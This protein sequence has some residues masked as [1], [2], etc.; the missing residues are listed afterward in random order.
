MASVI[1]TFSY[2]MPL[3]KQSTGPQISTNNCGVHALTCHHRK[4]ETCVTME[5]FLILCTFIPVNALC[6]QNNQSELENREFLM[7]T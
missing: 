4:Q 1:L 2:F 5:T 3:I 6:H 7:H